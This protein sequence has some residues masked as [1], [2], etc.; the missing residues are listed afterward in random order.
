MLVHTRLIG[1]IWQVK[2]LSLGGRGRLMTDGGRAQ[3]ILMPGKEI[4][5]MSAECAGPDREKDR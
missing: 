3:A 1:P 2:K 4:L 5:R